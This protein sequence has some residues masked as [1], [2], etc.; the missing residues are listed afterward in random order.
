M[1]VAVEIKRDFLHDL[2]ILGVGFNSHDQ[3]QPNIFHV[4]LAHYYIYS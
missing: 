1:S 4:C 3:S 2:K